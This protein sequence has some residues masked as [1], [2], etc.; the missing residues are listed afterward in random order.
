MPVGGGRAASA[1]GGASATFEHLAEADGAVAGVLSHQ[2]IASKVADGEQTV[3]R[4]SDAFEE[5]DGTWGDAVGGAVGGAWGDAVGGA[6][7]GAGAVALRERASDCEEGESTSMGAGMGGPAGGAGGAGGC[8]LLMQL[9]D[10]RVS[11]TAR[12]S[13]RVLLRGASWLSGK[14]W[15]GDA[16]DTSSVLA[17]VSMARQSQRTNISRRRVS[18]SDMQ[19]DAEKERSRRVSRVAR[20]Y[21]YTRRDEVAWRESVSGQSR[22]SVGLQSHNV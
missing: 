8:V 2:V 7:G 5:G 22:H 15:S 16:N 21:L 4:L 14:L 1:A 11:E 19:K 10:R 3:G 17:K 12:E 9:E 18:V 13:S 20:M 6:V